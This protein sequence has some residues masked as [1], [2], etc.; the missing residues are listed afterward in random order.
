MKSV[1]VADDNAPNREL[2]SVIL[3]QNGFRVLRAADGN[4]ALEKIRQERP[5]LVLLDIH[6]PGLDGYRTLQRIRQDLSLTGLPVVAVTASA[7][8]DDEERAFASG[9]TAYLAKPYEAED[10]VNLVKRLL[11]SG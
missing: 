8:A 10:V 9:F 3:E 5:D 11:S 1:L 7:M 2:T 6:M 4:E